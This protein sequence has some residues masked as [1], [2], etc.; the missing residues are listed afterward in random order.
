M[1]VFPVMNA[2][3]IARAP[4]IVNAAAINANPQAIV[5]ALVS[6]STCDGSKANAVVSTISPVI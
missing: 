6:L 4:L 5:V 1:D 2:L 3:E